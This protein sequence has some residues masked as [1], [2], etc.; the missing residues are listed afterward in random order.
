LPRPKS[1]LGIDTR[2]ADTLGELDD[3]GNEDCIGAG[4]MDSMSDMVDKRSLNHRSC[5]ASDL[6]PLGDIEDCREF[7]AELATE[8]SDGSAIRDFVS[9]FGDQSKEHWLYSDVSSDGDES[10]ILSP[11]IHE[12]IREVCASESDETLVMATGMTRAQIEDLQLIPV[13]GTVRILFSVDRISLRTELRRERE[14]SGSGDK[15]FLRY[16]V[17]QL[18]RGY[19]VAHGIPDFAAKYLGRKISLWIFGPFSAA[20]RNRER[21]LALVEKFLQDHSLSAVLLSAPL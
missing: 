12:A 20:E 16:G 17:A 18:A 4:W 21:W 6:P 1:F 5:E 3:T 13:V 11:L 2:E 10:I 15:L 8:C 14:S 7:I 19:L 9:E